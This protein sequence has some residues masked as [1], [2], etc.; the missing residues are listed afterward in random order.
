MSKIPRYDRKSS[1]GAPFNPDFASGNSPKIKTKI[2]LPV[3]PRKSTV[4]TPSGSSLQTEAPIVLTRSPDGSVNLQN[5]E[6]IDIRDVSTPS[7]FND[8]D[9]ELDALSSIASLDT[10]NLQRNQESLQRDTGPGS[11]VE[12]AHLTTPPPVDEV[13]GYNNG[14]LFQN[15]TARDSAANSPHTPSPPHNATDIQSPDFLPPNTQSSPLLFPPTADSV[16]T[17]PLLSPDVTLV[18]HPPTHSSL[19]TPPPSAFTPFTPELTHQSSISQQRRDPLTNYPLQQTLTENRFVPISDYTMPP[20]LS[21]YLY[22]YNTVSN[23]SRWTPTPPM[24]PP[25]PS[26]LS[27]SMFPPDSRSYY[28]L[29]SSVD[30]PDLTSMSYGT[31]M[32]TPSPIPSL[33]STPDGIT[34]HR[35]TFDNFPLYADSDGLTQQ[36]SALR[37]AL[38]ESTRERARLI[39]V[40][41]EQELAIKSRTSSTA[42]AGSAGYTTE[43]QLLRER[44]E[45]LE[46][47]NLQ[48]SSAQ[49]GRDESDTRAV[50]QE[51]TRARNILASEFEHLKAHQLQL[52][53]ELREERERNS[54]PLSPVG[55]VPHLELENSQLRDKLSQL[56]GEQSIGTETEVQRL[57]L[58]LLESEQ[59]ASLRL[60][61]NE[62]YFMEQIQQKQDTCDRFAQA[63]KQLAQEL[64]EED[65]S[66]RIIQSELQSVREQKEQIE[67]ELLSQEDLYA[68]LQQQLMEKQEI[69]CELEMKQG[70]KVDL[71][72]LDTLKREL[73]RLKVEKEGV[74]LKLTQEMQQTLQY[75]EA[76]K[77]ADGEIAR[78]SR[79]LQSVAR[80][81]ESGGA[82]GISEALEAA[83]ETNQSLTND[84][85]KKRTA[86]ETLKENLTRIVAEKRRLE[87]DYSLLEQR[88]GQLNG[89]LEQRTQECFTAKRQIENLE[90]GASIAVDQTRSLEDSK[91]ALSSLISLLSQIISD[92]ASAVVFSQADHQSFAQEMKFL[93]DEVSCP[94][95]SEE[96]SPPRAFEN[97]RHLTQRQGQQVQQLIGNQSRL[98]GYS[99]E[100]RLLRTR[101]QKLEGDKLLCEGNILE[102][103]A[104]N[105]SLQTK[106]NFNSP[107]TNRN[108]SLTLSQILPPDVFSLVNQNPGHEQGTLQSQLEL[109][110]QASPL[111]DA[112]PDYFNGELREARR[113][114]MESQDLTV[115]LK[116]DLVKSHGC[117]VSLQGANEDTIR[118]SR[119]TSRRAEAAEAELQRMRGEAETN[120]I[121]RIHSSAEKIEKIDSLEQVLESVYTK[122]TQDDRTFNA[123]FSKLVRIE[124]SADQSSIEILN[125]LRQSSSSLSLPRIVDT[126]LKSRQR[127]LSKLSDK[128]SEAVSL[129]QQLAAMR[130]ELSAVRDEA[131]NARVK[132][133]EL[134]E[135]VSVSEAALS[136]EKSRTVRLVSELSGE[137]RGRELLEDEL[138]DRERIVASL[139]HE[140]EQE[141]FLQEQQSSEREAGLSTQVEGLRETNLQ[142]KRDW[143]LL[144]NRMQH[145]QITAANQ[146]EQLNAQ[147]CQTQTEVTRLK[148]ENTK[149]AERIK[150]E[151]YSLSQLST[152][153]AR[154]IEAITLELTQNKA[155][156]SR[157]HS[158]LESQR[159]RLADKE[160]KFAD[161]VGELDELRE[162]KQTLLA[163][164]EA[165]Q[166][167][168]LAEAKQ[169]FELL[170]HESRAMKEENTRLKETFENELPNILEGNK[171]ERTKLQQF[172]E[173]LSDKN[174]Q[175]TQSLS[176]HKS[177]LSRS[178]QE[179]SRLTLAS[180]EQFESV[181]RS[182]RELE[183]ELG[184]LKHE[185]AS[186]IIT[187][188]GE[189]PLELMNRREELDHYS[190]N[191]ENVSL[192]NVIRKICQENN[193]L[194]IRCHDLENSILEGRA[195]SLPG[196]ST[197]DLQDHS[198]IIYFKKSN[199][200][201]DSKPNDR[202]LRTKKKQLELLRLKLGY[203]LRELRMYKVLKSAYDQ[204]IDDLKSLLSESGDK[205]E[206]CIQKITELEQL[207][208]RDD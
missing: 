162:R 146:V 113:E 172:I 133:T 155:E 102:L 123:E 93:F 63:N 27:L 9:S 125:E 53:E 170:E 84:L 85:Q 134:R 89:S 127:I 51:A 160:R 82:Q 119:I 19:H 183:S 150:Q 100:V 88:A 60:R 87:T 83:N 74:E 109:T 135:L 41:K 99:E 30:S 166:E 79:E 122:I 36:L 106:V 31:P 174:A 124:D 128:T 10:P 29:R 118:N 40:I 189:I 192:P 110:G 161:I 184:R 95:A 144:N 5:L 206:G 149:L 121:E 81:I 37:E 193:Q 185:Y 140:L 173:D 190:R 16:E 25:L 1:T 188:Q 131:G 73:E 191:S 129:S 142:L 75:M 176:E 126:V 207:C 147:L 21:D 98:D 7:H 62:S 57:T 198:D 24:L 43:M 6:H 86:F 120:E 111:P 104:N 164:Y 168:K 8:D 72:V 59:L 80:E 97:I 68:A 112:P 179:L 197:P 11:G 114:L 157:C 55:R 159:N 182:K 44:C 156:V 69:V 154:E 152:S 96:N 108:E 196:T 158:E 138:R 103:L 195:D 58:A 167:S 77:E 71:D 12:T 4:N 47:E 181:M 145:H 116:Q 49:P 34:L 22:E 54:S 20:P 203:T 136:E 169:K 165:M 90:V 208:L 45:F 50:L 18:P 46:N 26:P 61:E 14:I 67:R 139:R 151:T 187:L 78:L 38:D 117:I 107:H 175:L 32:D 66:K 186:E 115:R 101:L 199:C 178:K 28:P 180:E 15:A 56:A 92:L 91:Q 163:Q 141:R 153:Q 205:Y 17:D 94:G 13:L 76:K 105:A 194:K 35:P 148:G 65:S 132:L 39:E 171:E 200:Y 33:L 204:Q 2:P 64:N 130:I 202:V 143:E 23:P 70:L 48:L 201:S 137:Q 3:S 177:E 52:E 42:P